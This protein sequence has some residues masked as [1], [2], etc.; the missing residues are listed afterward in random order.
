MVL[1]KYTYA[2]AKLNHPFI[3]K[4]PRINS[5]FYKRESYYYSQKDII[6][7]PFAFWCVYCLSLYLGKSLCYIYM[8]YR[9]IVKCIFIL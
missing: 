3:I 4:L 9:N 7:K 1:M 6:L 8:F 2:L 5:D